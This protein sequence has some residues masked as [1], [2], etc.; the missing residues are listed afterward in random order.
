MKKPR[1]LIDQMVFFKL[2]FN[3][4]SF[5]FLFLFFFLFFLFSF[6]LY[7][8]CFSFPFFLL[9]IFSGNF[10]IILGD[11]FLRQFVTIFDRVQQR[12]GFATAG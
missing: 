3:I 4:F 12:M 11:T 1:R 6:F 2:I 7:F 9:F 8:L 10:G 5:F